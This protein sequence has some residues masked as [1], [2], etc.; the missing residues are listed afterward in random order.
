MCILLLTFSGSSFRLLL[1]V[2]LNCFLCFTFLCGIFSYL[3]CFNM[4]LEFV[5]VKRFILGTAKEK[6]EIHF[7]EFIHGKNVNSSTLKKNKFHD[8]GTL[9]HPAYS[10]DIVPSDYQL[11]PAIKQNLGCHRFK[12][13]RVVKII[14]TWWL[15]TYTIGSS[16][17]RECGCV[18]IWQMAELWRG[19]FTIVVG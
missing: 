4:S 7:H 11:F 13:D 14:M 2:C 16:I 10:S 19:L 1:N 5:L 3:F 9:E 6:N 12:G 8:N 15:I 17:N 18:T